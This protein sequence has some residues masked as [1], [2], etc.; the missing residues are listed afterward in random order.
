[1]LALG[2][3]LALAVV[4]G[5]ELVLVLETDLELVL[6]LWKAQGLGNYYLAQ[7]PNHLKRALA[8]ALLK[9]LAVAL[10]LAPRS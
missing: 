5:K 1:M 9:E 2:Q 3:E 4:L 7:F 6:V 10:A 8:L